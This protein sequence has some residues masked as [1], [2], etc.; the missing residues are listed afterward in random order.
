MSVLTLRI[1]GSIAVA[2][3]IT[4][5]IADVFADN[6]EEQTSTPEIASLPMPRRKK[7][8]RL[9]RQLARDTY[10]IDER[11]DAVLERILMDIP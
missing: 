11:L 7:V 1:D 9:R 6:L 2:E 5:A 4:N 8:I 10:D 3:S